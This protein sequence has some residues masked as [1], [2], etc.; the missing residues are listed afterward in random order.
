LKCGVFVP[1]NPKKKGPS[2]GSQRSITNAVG[3]TVEKRNNRETGVG[4]ERPT[5]VL[6]RKRIGKMFSA[7]VR[8]TPTSKRKKT[9]AGRNKKLQWGEGWW[10][11]RER[12]I[13]ARSGNKT[14]TQAE[15]RFEEEKSGGKG[16]EPLQGGGD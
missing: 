14:P 1:L 9:S 10:K 15:N 12:Q 4:S 13:V 6:G 11:K 8:M 7:H 16:G 3:S 5:Q 2:E